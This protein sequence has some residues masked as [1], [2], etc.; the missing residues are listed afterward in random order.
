MKKRLKILIAVILFVVICFLSF[1]IIQ[2]IQKKKEVFEKIKTL[3]IFSFQTIDN[4]EFNNK[5]ILSQENIL[6]IA[7]NPGCDFC[8]AEA[9]HIKSDLPELKAFKIL[10][11]S[12]A[13]I[14][15][16]KNFALKYGL[17]NQKNIQFLIDKNN[18]LL[19]NFGVS[20]FPT[21][22]VYSSKQVLLKTY[23]GVIKPEQLLK[24]L[25]NQQK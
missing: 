3:P 20:S 19:K 7:F 16:V 12:S 1:G 18:E 22:F 10:M 15:S 5:N 25:A 8:Q 24:D 4:Q 9:E 21:S 11:V 23:K 2:V 17:A 6:L 14:D 13:P